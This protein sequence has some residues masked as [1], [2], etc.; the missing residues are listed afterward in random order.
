MTVIIA[1]TDMGSIP[2]CQFQLIPFYQ[3]QF[4][5]KFINSNSFFYQ[6]Y[7]YLLLLSWVGTPSTYLVYLLLVVY[8]PSRKKYF[9]IKKLIG[10]LICEFFGR[11]LQ[12]QF[13]QFWNWKLTISSN[14]GIELTRCLYNHIIVFNSLVYNKIF[15]PR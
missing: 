15:K 12:F 11:K 9:W 8:I 3:F 7:F 6:L 5:I 14:S 2:F 13:Y 1:V 4:Y 10:K